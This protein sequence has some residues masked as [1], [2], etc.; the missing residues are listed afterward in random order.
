MLLVWRRN[1][2]QRRRLQRH[3]PKYAKGQKDALAEGLLELAE[4]GVC[5]KETWIYGCHL[6]SRDLAAARAAVVAL[7]APG[8][9]ASV[10]PEGIVHLCHPGEEEKVAAM[11]STSDAKRLSR[12]Q[13]ED[14]RRADADKLK[15]SVRMHNVIERGTE[16]VVRWLMK[17]RVAKVA[18][19]HPSKPPLSNRRRKQLKSVVHVL[20]RPNDPLASCNSSSVVRRAVDTWADGH[21]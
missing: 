9:G 17:P 16:Q 11:Q 14:Q 6:T 15:H 20:Q 10:L 7:T 1:R 4:H 12:D 8:G 19:R 5:V 21:K 13:H 18:G 2:L 3:R